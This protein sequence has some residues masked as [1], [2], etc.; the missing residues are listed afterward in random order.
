MR[1]CNNPCKWMQW[2][3]QRY[4]ILRDVGGFSAAESATL[5]TS[6][7]RFFEA[8]KERGHDPEQWGEL[9]KRNPGGHPR[10]TTAKHERNTR[11]YH[12]LR[13]LG[14]DSRFASEYSQNPVAFER[15][16]RILSGEEME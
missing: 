10:G 3:S 4:A 8:M 11:F 5:C 16:K 12:E 2:R 15:G 14:A 6:P 13:K 7:V 9:S 1:G